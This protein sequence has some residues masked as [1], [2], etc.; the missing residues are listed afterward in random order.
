MLYSRCSELPN[1]AW[2]EV[3]YTS[4]TTPTKYTYNGQYSDVS[5][6]GLM[7]CNAR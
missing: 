2:E 3:R 4:G 6:F 7:Y 5:D 1:K